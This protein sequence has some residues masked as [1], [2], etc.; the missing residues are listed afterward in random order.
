MRN[1]LAID[2]GYRTADLLIVPLE[3]DEKKYDEARGRALQDEFIQRLSA[4]PEVEAVSYGLVMPLSGGKFLSSI[5]VE[6]RQPLPNEQM[7]FDASVVG[8]QYHQTMGIPIVEGRG[9]TE[10]D[11]KGAPGVVIINQAMSQRLWPGG[12]SLAKRLQLA[13]NGPTLESVG[14]TANPRLHDLTETPIPHFDLPALQRDYDSYT[15]ITVQ[16]KGSATKVIPVVR[17]ELRALDSTL[18]GTQVTTMS[19]QIGSAL[20]AMRLASTLVATFGLMALLLASIG[21]YGVMSY[22]V[23]RRTREIGIRMALGAEPGDVLK[24]VIRRGMLLTAIGVVVGLASA[25]AA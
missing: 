9:F 4:L 14:I 17:D 8:P 22:T 24:L 11:R 12:D 1:L 21:L 13:T 20:A 23:S 5:F 7:A 18:A 6:A 16:T 25:F 19:E 3:L 2:P 15:N 10:Q